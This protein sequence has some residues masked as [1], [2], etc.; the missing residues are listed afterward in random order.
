MK[1]IQ[2]I[3]AFFFLSGSALS[4]RAIP[5]SKNDICWKGTIGKNIPVFLHYQVDGTIAVGEITYLNTKTRKP[6][7]IIGTLEADK[8]LRLLEFDITGNITGI[9]TGTPGVKAFKGSWFSPKTRKELEMGFTK[10]DTIIPSV[11]LKADMKNIYS[12]YHYQYGA[13]GYQGDFDCGTVTNNKISF[14]L[15]SVTGEPGRNIADVQGE[16]IMVTDN[17]F[18]YRM[19]H[20]QDCAFKVTFYN[21]FIYVKYTEG[22][23]EGQFGHNATAEGIFLKVKK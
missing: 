11:S 4:H 3:I 9:L 5:V 6:I 2:L 14:S 21:G 8:S 19:P 12:D 17:S 16:N 20:T 1:S 13:A 10:A 15:F 7:K 18:T 23:C 22:T